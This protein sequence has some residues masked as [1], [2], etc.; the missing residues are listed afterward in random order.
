M[1][2]GD[3]SEFYGPGA[4][5]YW[6]EVVEE[7]IPALGGVS[8]DQFFGSTLAGLELMQ[9]NSIGKAVFSGNLSNLAGITSIKIGGQTFS[10]TQTDTSGGF[11][12][13]SFNLTGSPTFNISE[14]YTLEFIK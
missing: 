10:V 9:G 14:P 12:V 6:L 7:G 1:T 2:F 5:A 3:A 8:N 4:I 11:L 13:I